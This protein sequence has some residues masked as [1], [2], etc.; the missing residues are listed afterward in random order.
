MN[1]ILPKDLIQDAESGDRADH[2]VERANA[3]VSP[4]SMGATISHFN[5]VANLAPSFFGS[6]FVSS[7]QWNQMEEA[8]RILSGQQQ[9]LGGL[10]GNTTSIIDAAGLQFPS[11]R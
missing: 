8:Q 4:N 3:D 2:W 5:N 9:T 11:F 1:D 6:S 10:H 7:F